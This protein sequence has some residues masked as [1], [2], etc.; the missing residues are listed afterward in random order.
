MD[1]FLFTQLCYGMEF[2]KC[3]RVPEDIYGEKSPLDNRFHMT[4]EGNPEGYIPDEDYTS[5]KI[6][7]LFEKYTEK[8]MLFYINYNS[9]FKWIPRSWCVL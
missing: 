7:K 8:L 6:F 3:D 2:K 4:I 1:W 5:I 9:S